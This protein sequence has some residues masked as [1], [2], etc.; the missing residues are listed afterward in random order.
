[1]YFYLFF[2]LHKINQ[3]LFE[4]DFFYHVGKLRMMKKIGN[5][6]LLLDTIGRRTKDFDAFQYLCKIHIQGEWEMVKQNILEDMENENQMAYTVIESHMDKPVM[7][8]EEFY[9]YLKKRIEEEFYGSIRY[10]ICW[11][12]NNTEKIALIYCDVIHVKHIHINI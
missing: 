4:Y 1:M 10:A 2:A 3:T 11:K 8:D 12:E 5:L 6:V 9:W 7:G